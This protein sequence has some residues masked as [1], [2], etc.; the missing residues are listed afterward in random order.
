M[1]NDKHEAVETVILML[2]NKRHT[3]AVVH[4]DFPLLEDGIV[5]NPFLRS[6]KFNLSNKFLELDGKI[7]LLGDNGTVIP[8]NSSKIITL[9]TR[10]EKGEVIIENSPY[11]VQIHYH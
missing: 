8:K 9:E 10:K 4:D 11:Q 3:F 2:Q 5:E 6:Y 1:G 7:Y